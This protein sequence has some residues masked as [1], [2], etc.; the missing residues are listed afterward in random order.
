MKEKLTKKKI[1]TRTLVSSGLISVFMSFTLAYGYAFHIHRQSPLTSIKTVL[2]FIV[3]TI[4]FM[5]ISVFLFE[6]LH[7]AGSKIKEKKINY[8]KKTAILTFVVAFVVMIIAWIPYWLASY[9]GFFT[10]DAGNAFIQHFYG[11]EYSTHHPLLHTILIGDAFK[12]A[13]RISPENYNLG[14]VFLSW[15]EIITGSFIFS[16]MLSYIYY[17]SGKIVYCVSLLYFAFFPT[18]ALFSTCST[19]DSFNS[20][21]I[22]ALITFI[23]F[24]TRKEIRIPDI[25]LTT[26][27]VALILLYRKNNLIA[28]SVFAPVFLISW[29][30]ERL[31]WLIAFV[32]GFLLFFAVS[33]GLEIRYNPIKGE[34]CE[35]LSVPLQQ[36][37]RV[38]IN[39][40]EKMFTEE[41]QIYFNS[42]HPYSLDNY[43]EQDADFVKAMMNDEVLRKTLPRFIKMWIRIGVNHPK[44]YIEAFIINTYQAWYPFCDITSYMELADST[45]T[46]FK[47]DV[48]TPGTLDSKLPGFYDF[49]W[50][51]SRETS[52]YRI[53]VI[54]VMFTI[55]FYMYA[56][57]LV[58]AIGIFRKDMRKVLLSVYLMTFVITALFGPLVLPRYYL[59]LYYSFPL[60]LGTIFEKKIEIF[61]DN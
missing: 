39:E 16:L 55:A 60:M 35:M 10:Y 6:F 14:I 54:G 38:Y 32:A 7:S 12:L 21:F 3:L 28:L 26:I 18:I 52:L 42:I 48:E 13:V 27:L 34:M 47:C 30:K 50:K 19:K 51:L 9:P 22:V 53:P 43:H 31:K 24:K 1:N 49:L 44:E 8:T 25:V 2:S 20:F 41:E 11:L 5:L 40:G 17:I 37:G 58:F 4:V 57:V 15:I 36:M 33:K 23:M 46:Y 29:K 56:M 45:Y 61:K 59:Y